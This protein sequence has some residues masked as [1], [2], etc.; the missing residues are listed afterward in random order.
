MTH[1][2][3]VCGIPLA[4][5]PVEVVITGAFLANGVNLTVGFM[6]PE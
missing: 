2:L 1:N 3:D 4:I 6:A 5:A